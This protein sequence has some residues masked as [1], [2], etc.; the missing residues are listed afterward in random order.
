M[1]TFLTKLFTIQLENINY[2]LERVLSIELGGQNMVS[3]V[4]KK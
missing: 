3:E 4:S 1:K 2:H